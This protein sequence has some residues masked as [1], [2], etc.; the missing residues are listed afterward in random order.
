MPR[1]LIFPIFLV[2]ALVLGVAGLLWWGG[3]STSPGGS[4]EPEAFV[5]TPG[6]SAA[7]IGKNLQKEGFIKSALAFK[8]FM[9]FSG[10]AGKIQAGDYRLAKNLSL[11]Q[12]VRELV[13]GPVA[14]W[15]T[16][17]EG[18][19]REEIG[20]KTVDAL[21]LA[22]DKR[23]TFLDEFNELTKNKE[24]FLFPDTYLFF[25]NASAS[26]VVKRFENN[27]EKKVDEELLAKAKDQKLT[28]NQLI[29]LASI[30]E[31]E[32][33]TDEERPI[34]AGILLKR[35][36]AGIPLQVDATLQYAISN[37]KCQI[38][39]V[40]C[41]WWPQ[42]HSEDKQVKSPYNT[43]ANRGLPPGPIANPGLSSIKAAAN[44]EDSEYWFYLH[45]TD[46]KIHYAKTSEEH[47]ENIRKY[48]Q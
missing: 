35:I 33:R 21:K 47:L 36:S 46:G 42:V 22:G 18:F 4:A 15:V 19:R 10:N 7:T 41:E 37:F 20:R 24:G 26:A 39:N 12:L 5:I 43:Y 29:T 34:V 16:I 45:E 40:K 9:Q 3:S 38:S 6:S 23:S 27:F 14:V 2:L 30:I 11:A 8:L 13:R 44:P 28:T 17:P 32:T 31:R 25:K 48:L 1:I